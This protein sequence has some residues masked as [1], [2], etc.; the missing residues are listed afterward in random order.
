VVRQ[1]AYAAAGVDIDA[2]NRTKKRIGEVV[3]STLGSEVLSNIG[4]FGGIYVPPW[5]DYTEPALVASTDSVGTKLKI[6]FITGDH[7]VVGADIVAHCA[8]DILVQGARPLFFLDYLGMGRHDPETVEEVIRGIAEGC[9][10]CGCALLGGEMAELPGIYADGEYDLAGTIVGIAEREKLIDKSRVRPGDLLIGLASTG[11]HTN[12]YSLAR[13]LLF[14]TAGLTVDTHVEQLGAAV[15]EGLMAPHRCYVPSVLP[16]L[17]STDVKAMAHITGGGLIDNLPRALPEPLGARIRRG[18][19]EEPPIFSLL[20]EIGQIED[21]EMF[22]TFN[23]GVGLALIVSAEQQERALENLSGAGE[24]AFHLG[25]V[26]EDPDHAVQ[27][28]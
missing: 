4:S 22:Q 21:L 2:A 23:M 14:E 27:I 19:W 26:I 10:T 12:G 8:N 13:K 25:E 16:L 28:V 11:L 17:A 18:A 9:K 6:A 24:S 20:Q 15:G 7:D 1:K 3:R 5:K